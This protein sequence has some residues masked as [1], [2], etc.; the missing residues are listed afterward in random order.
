MPSLSRVRWARFVAVAGLLFA[1]VL[2]SA[3]TPQWVKD[4]ATQTV[5]AY[6]PDTNAVVLI[7]SAN[8]TVTA[9]GEYTEHNRRAVRILRNEG[10]EEAQLAVYLQGRDKLKFIHC[11]SIDSK[12][13]EFELKDKEFEQRGFAEYLYDDIH[14]QTG[15]CPA[16]EPGSTIAFEYEVQHHWWLNEW[17]RD[18]QEDIPVRESRVTL[19]VPAG[20]EYKAFWANGQPVEPSKTSDGEWQWTL[21]DLAAIDHE[22]MRP[23]IRALSMRMKLVYFPPDQN[24]NSTSTWNALGRWYTQL[25]ADRRVPSPA[26]VEKAH[27]L[28]QGKTDFD[29]KVRA[30]ASFLQTDVRYVAIEIGIGGYQPHPA[31]DVFKA[32]YG[33]CKDKATLL[34]T[35]LHE[36]GVESDYLVINTNRGIAV[37][38]LPSSG[39]FNH[40]ILAIELPP[41]VKE[42]TYRAVV[43]SKAGKRYLLFDPTDTFTPLGELR[44]DLQSTNALLVADGGGELIATPLLSPATNLLSRIGH[45]T[46]GNDGVLSGEV[47]EDR[48]GDHA[49]S[50][51]AALKYSNEQQRTQHLEGRLNRSLKGFTLQSADI[52]QLDQTDEKLSIDYKFSDPGYGQIRGPLMLV[53]PRVL[54][55]KSMALERKPRH[56]PFQFERA[57]RETDVYEFNLPEGYVVDDIP[58]AV[59][60]DMGFASYESKFEVKEKV[61]RY[62]REF[63]RRDVL[64]QADRT[65]DLRKLEGIIGADE[66]AAVVLK[67]IQ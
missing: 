18:F 42:G 49:A 54:G 20:W 19:K 23:S 29:G 9:P 41:D 3:V 1:P 15:T 59:K 55:E 24:F 63:V 16:G 64:I 4:V 6:E 67:R 10:R 28:T 37:P 39:S 12:G 30:L 48:T 22:P 66:N 14:W 25:T 60:V 33:D 56:F 32:R 47:I 7:D 38:E 17:E 36:V 27:Q 26:L 53:R 65:A 11:W 52:R 34:S 44:G 50:E 40:V 35:M 57:T 5:P 61:L 43:T 31:A 51:R 58:E 46:I 45:F 13:R 62:S 21:H 2:S 8:I